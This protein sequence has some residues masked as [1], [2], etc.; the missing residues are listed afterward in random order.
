VELG[1]T[2]WCARYNTF[3]F[4]AG[5]TTMYCLLRNLVER[6]VLL[7]F[8][9][10]LIAASMF[11]HALRDYFGET[12]TVACVAIGILALCVD[13]TAL[14]WCLLMLGVANTPGTLVGLVF[15][16]G[17][18]VWETRRLRHVAPVIGAAALILLESWLRRGS[19]FH[20][21]YEGNRG[22][23]TVLPYSG[24]PGFSYP[25]VFGVLSI[26]LSFGRGL[27]FFAPG[28]LLPLDPANPER[29]R[30]CYRYW[31][32][33]LAGLIII[34]AK[35]WAWY[36]DWWGPRFFLFASIPASLSMALA[37]NRAQKLRTSVLTGL[38]AALTLSVW[39]A[40]D[41]TIFDVGSS[42]ICWQNNFALESF[43]WYLPEFVSLW[44]P[45]VAPRFFRLDGRPLQFVVFCVVV[46]ICL[47][48]PLVRELATRTRHVLRTLDP[49]RRFRLLRI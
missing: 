49:I 22:A 14:G 29:L 38:L 19:P 43:C 11:P 46:W 30:A 7:N 39:V 35:W 5:L 3:V 12:F 45:F 20:T 48:T 37:I 31:L 8:L 44:R 41:A 33:F 18:R 23:Q 9:L 32:W 6:K 25:F 10:L 27:I 13:R 17:A 28:L 34:Y 21:G 40:I 1:A 47:A 4:T 26:F 24:L 15:V 42:T 2:W 36:G 16:A